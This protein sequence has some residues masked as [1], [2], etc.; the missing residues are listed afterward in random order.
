MKQ[1]I[2]VELTEEEIE[3]FYKLPEEVQQVLLRYCY[4]QAIYN[5]L[6]RIIGEKNENK[7]QKN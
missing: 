7:M 4:H 6:I 5:A 2:E 1:K 3:A